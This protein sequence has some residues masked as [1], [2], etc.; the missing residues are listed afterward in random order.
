MIYPIVPDRLQ[1][2]YIGNGTILSLCQ[3]A[4]SWLRE[5]TSRSSNRFNIFQYCR[6]R[7]FPF[8]IIRENIRNSKRKFGWNHFRLENRESKHQCQEF[9]KN[10]TY[11]AILLHFNLS[12]TYGHFTAIFQNVYF[13]SILY[14]QVLTWTIDVLLK[15]QKSDAFSGFRIETRVFIYVK[16]SRKQIWSTVPLRLLMFSIHKTNND[17]EIVCAIF[18]SSEMECNNK[19]EQSCRENLIQQIFVK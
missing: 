4:L 18:S 11:G 15:T 16:N 6:L 12:V 19:D 3:L 1:Q 5:L 2:H 10:A 9:L 7:K 8:R 13:F 17:S 14:F